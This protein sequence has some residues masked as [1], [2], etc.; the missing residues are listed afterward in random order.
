MTTT[1]GETP[2]KLYLVETTGYG[3]INISLVTEDIWNVMMNGSTASHS[4]IDSV[5]AKYLTFQSDFFRPTDSDWSDF[6]FNHLD[7]NPDSIDNDRVLQLQFL[8][9]NSFYSIRE[10]GEWCK[11]N[12]EV[13]IVDEWSGYIY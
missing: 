6:F 10:F 4:D 7:S 5:K 12:P 13:E 11:Q 2:M 8:A 1:P 3:D 9:Q